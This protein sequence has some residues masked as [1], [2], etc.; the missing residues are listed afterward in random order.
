MAYFWLDPTIPSLP[1]SIASL[2]E[3]SGTGPLSLSRAARGIFVGYDEHRRAYRI[4]PDGA[5]HYVV[6]RVVVFDE[7][8]II[9]RMLNRCTSVTSAVESSD[10]EFVP[11]PSIDGNG[12]P[13]TGCI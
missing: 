2:P 12:N 4:L 6:A 8:P 3:Y 13:G 7:R 5:V 11:P 9:R 1:Q 10:D